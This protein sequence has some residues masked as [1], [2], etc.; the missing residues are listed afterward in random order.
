MMLAWYPPT[1]RIL[2]G[3]Y[4]RFAANAFRSFRSRA[5]MPCRRIAILSYDI[6]IQGC[7]AVLL[8]SLADGARGVHLSA[9]KVA[10]KED[11]AAAAAGASPAGMGGSHAS[12]S[13]L[14]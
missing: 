13:A 5:D 10:F 12:S 3:H 14:A 9:G 2:M 7:S 4:N 6:D 1:F 8:A 11:T